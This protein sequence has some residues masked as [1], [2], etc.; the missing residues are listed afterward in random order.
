[1]R[2]DLCGGCQIGVPPLGP[3]DWRL[4]Q[5]SGGVVRVW[6]FYYQGVSDENRADEWA[7]GYTTDGSTPPADT[8]DVTQAVDH[9]PLSILQYDLPAQSN[10]TT[11]KV[12]LQT[13]R[14]DGSWI[15]SED[16][17]VE[18]ITVATAGP[19][20]PLDVERWPGSLDE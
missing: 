1:M 16:S 6:G 18:T 17:T 12:R 20:A 7:I 19:T 14:D 15:Y 13:R 2:L 11:V 10:G 4:E 8:P 3:Q 9:G 5:R